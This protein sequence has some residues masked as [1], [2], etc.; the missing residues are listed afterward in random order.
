MEKPGGSGQHWESLVEA[1]H[2][3][4]KGTARH[5]GLYEKHVSVL[6]MVEYRSK[7]LPIVRVGVHAELSAGFTAFSMDLYSCRDGEGHK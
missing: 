6:D 7:Q 3:P 5:C 1:R 4:K 2:L